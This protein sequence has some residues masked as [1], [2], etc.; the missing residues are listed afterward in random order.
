LQQ[1]VSRRHLRREP[2]CVSSTLADNSS[3]SANHTNREQPEHGLRSDS[4]LGRIIRVLADNATVV[5]SGTKLAHELDTSRSEVWRLV[6]QLRA[7]GVEIEGHP[8]TGYQLTS[9]PD[10]LLPEAL[11]PLLR[12][13]LFARD[14]RHYFRVGSTNIEALQ[15]A[16]VGA[17]EGSV[18]IAEE[19]TAGR[20][21]AG[22][23]WISEPSTGIY[24][25]V[26]LRPQIAPADA[27]LLSLIAG[28]AAHDTVASVTEIRSDIRWPNDLL[29]GDKKFC[30]ILTEMN[31]EVT[32]VRHAVVGIG[33]NV[34]QRSFPAELNDIA[35]SLQLESGRSW[36]RVAIVAALLRSLDVEYRQ[37]ISQ[38]IKARAS[39]FERFEQRSSY[40]RGK[41]V[42]VAENSGYDGVTAGLDDRG[43]LRVQTDTGMRT[44]LSGDVRPVS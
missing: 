20:G 44:V 12:G 36:S 29:I 24:V 3:I 39:L 38:D 10:L 33:I 21:R 27:L 30:G 14:I 34:N 22:H 18:F 7:F 43:F 42:H 28:I 41:R 9:V 2:L 6:Q 31:A 26:I 8:A 32:R 16:A 15:A 5:V 25:S 11:E 37:L 23:S 13:T 1:P 35:T 40:A 19:Q 17:S 4:R